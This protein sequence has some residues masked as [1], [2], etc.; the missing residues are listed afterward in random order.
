MAI[1]VNLRYT[2]KN[3]NARKFAEEMAAGGTVAAIRAEAGNPRYEYY[4]PLDDPETILLIDSW[5]SQEAIDPVHDLII[6]HPRHIP[7]I[8]LPL[9]VSDIVFSAE[10]DVLPELFHKAV[11]AFRLLV[12]ER[13]RFRG[14]D[15]AV[16][17]HRMCVPLVM[18]IAVVKRRFCLPG[19]DDHR[20]HHDAE[21]PHIVQEIRLHQ[22]QEVP[23]DRRVA[24]PP[25]LGV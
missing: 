15:R 5:E 20:I 23:V 6:A 22:H 2:G 25:F 24:H 7:A 13:L 1:T 3:G 4:Q 18:V 19:P 14:D 10:Q 8:R 21:E 11:R 9:P 12:P 16:V 17:L